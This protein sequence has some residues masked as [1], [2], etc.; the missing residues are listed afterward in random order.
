MDGT[1]YIEMD[2]LEGRTW[3]ASWSKA[4]GKN[5]GRS[6]RDGPWTH[7]PGVPRSQGRH[8]AGIV[9]RDLKPENLHVCPDEDEEL[10]KI[11]DFG[12]AKLEDSGPEGLRTRTG[13][14]MG[15]AYYMSPEQIDDAKDVD[16]R[17]DIYAVGVI[18]YELLSGS[19]PFTGHSFGQVV[20]NVLDFD[21]GSA[22]LAAAGAARRTGGRGSPRHGQAPG[23]S[24]PESGGA[25]P[26]VAAVSSAKQRSIGLCPPAGAAS[27]GRG[28]ATLACDTEAAPDW[29]P[30]QAEIAESHIREP[31]ARRAAA[32]AVRAWSRVRPPVLIGCGLTVAAAVV[33]AAISAIWWP[34]RTPELRP[35]PASQG[36]PSQSAPLVGSVPAPPSA[37]S[38]AVVSGVMVSAEPSDGGQSGGR[39]GAENRA[40]RG[41]PGPRVPQ[42][43]LPRTRPEP[44]ARLMQEHGTR[45]RN[46]TSGSPRSWLLV[47]TVVK[48]PV[49]CS[50]A[51]MVASI[52][53]A[54]GFAKGTILLHPAP[55]AQ[56]AAGRRRRARQPHWTT[57]LP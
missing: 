10:L 52:L 3:R 15:T 41:R 49:A 36:V 44:L 17:T 21:A 16:A 13:S 47:R 7:G 22:R 51:L 24:L 8:D 34:L 38:G 30:E 6:S 14:T 55:S 1:P 33:V 54:Q 27:T 9:H 12:I 40:G 25:G 45:A 31:V 50:L 56:P 11:L 26:G 2:F 42:P 53:G 37:P 43:V 29:V 35:A 28:E 4:S 19:R 18:L 39:S 57:P 46:S 5:N 32:E 48:S 23:R 20:K